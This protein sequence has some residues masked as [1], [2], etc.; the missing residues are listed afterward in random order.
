MVAREDRAGG[1]DESARQRAVLLENDAMTYLANCIILEQWSARSSVESENR[2]A[3]KHA[4]SK[5][6]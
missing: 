2:E 5:T 1:K 6:R 3:V 4:N